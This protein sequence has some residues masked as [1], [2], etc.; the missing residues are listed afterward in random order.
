M[1]ANNKKRHLLATDVSDKRLQVQEI[2][3]IDF[4][5]EDEPNEI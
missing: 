3:D 5:I 4:K 2:T 1:S